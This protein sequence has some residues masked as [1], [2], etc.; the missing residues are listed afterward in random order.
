MTKERQVG[1]LDTIRKDHLSR[2]LF[3]A[4]RISNQNI[5]DI[6][7]GCGYG[8]SLLHM[9]CNAV[10][11]VDCEPEA[12]DYAKENYPGPEYRLCMAEEVH[13]SWDA[14]VSFETLEHLPDPLSVLNANPAKR[15]IASVPNEEVWQFSSENFKTDKYPHLRH[16]T[17]AQFEEL[18]NGAGYSVEERYCQKD[19][20]GELQP[21][22]DGIFLI[23]V[24]KR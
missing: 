6:A 14:V 15:L 20:R 23:Y 9:A 18:V 5:L 21:G 22:T 1:A 2:Y 24:C 4:D 11:G 8:S 16:Y 7:C 3:A 10:V 17:P 13:G 12:I 19:K